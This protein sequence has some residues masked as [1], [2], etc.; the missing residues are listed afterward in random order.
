MRVVFDTSVIVAALRSRNG[1]S[2]LWLTAVLLGQ[3]TPVVS[4]PLVLEYEAV[5]SRP[6]NL[7]VFGLSLAQVERFLDG[8]CS[9]AAHVETSNL[10][11]PLLRDPDDEMVLETAVQGRAELLLT[12]NIRDFDGCRA[13]GIEAIAPGPAW[14]RQKGT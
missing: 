10:W 14:Q 13:F 5:L 2:R 1:A 6:D 4:V 9:I 3:H 11:R 12:F 7:T 8:F